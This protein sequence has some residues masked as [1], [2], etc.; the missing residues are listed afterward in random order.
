MEEKLIDIHGVA[1]MMSMHPKS[2]RKI[3][4]EDDHFLQEIVFSPRVKRWKQ[5]DILRWIDVKSQQQT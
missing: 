4:R 1:E 3:I 2:M 5:S